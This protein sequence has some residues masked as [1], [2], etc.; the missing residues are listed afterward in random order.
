L[1]ESYQNHLRYTEG[2]QSFSL[3]V[4]TCNKGAFYCFKSPFVYSNWHIF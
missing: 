4:T 3:K 1:L 2:D